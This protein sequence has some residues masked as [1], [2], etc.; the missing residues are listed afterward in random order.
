MVDQAVQERQQ[1]EVFEG[2]RQQLLELLVIDTAEKPAHVQFEE[3]A[4]FAAERLRPA[5]GPVAALS[6]TFSTAPGPTISRMA[7]P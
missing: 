3:V 6:S 2:P 1:P 4:V 7:A 5:D